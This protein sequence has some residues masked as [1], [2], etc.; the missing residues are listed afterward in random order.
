MPYIHPRP[1]SRYWPRSSD[2]GWTCTSTFRGNNSAS[3]IFV[4]LLSR[5]QLLKEK[6]CSLRSK[7]CPLRVGRPLSCANWTSKKIVPFL[8]MTEKHGDISGGKVSA[9]IKRL[10]LLLLSRRV[11]KLTLKEPGKIAADNIFTHLH[12]VK[13]CICD[14]SGVRP[15]P[16][17]RVCAH[18]HDQ[19]VQ[20]LRLG[21]FL[22]NYKG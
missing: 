18:A 1:D 19:T 12:K 17:L 8:R 5:G 14:I 15:H 16:R 10:R 11:L 3:F 7:F 13:E 2:Y 20:F 9:N 4:S 6:I 21:Q 22:S